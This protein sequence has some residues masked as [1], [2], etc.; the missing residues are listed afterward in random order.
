MPKAI[1][2]AEILIIIL[3]FA[4][5]YSGFAQQQMRASRDR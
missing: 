3:F 4:A 2:I 5:P 1:R